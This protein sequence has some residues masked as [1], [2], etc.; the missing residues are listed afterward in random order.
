MYDL[1]L[2]S[3]SSGDK[4]ARTACLMSAAALLDGRG[5]T[6]EY[7]CPMVRTIGIAINDTKW[8]ESD[9]ERTRVLMP[10]ATDPRLCASSVD[11]GY[12]AQR[13]RAHRCA[14]MACRVWLPRFLDGVPVGADYAAALRDLVPIVNEYEAER[15]WHKVGLVPRKE[16]GGDEPR[17]PPRV[18]PVVLAQWALEDLVKEFQASSVGLS[19][20]V[21]RVICSQRPDL[22]SVIRTEAIALLLDCCEVRGEG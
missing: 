2:I 16:G 1:R 12:A 10:V 7:P 18:S 9:E 8:W 22:V 6:D 13:T 5:L 4:F 11:V 3:G 21:A 19:L 15:A 14:D 20:D 17:D